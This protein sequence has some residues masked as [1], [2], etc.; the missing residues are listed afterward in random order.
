TVLTETE[1]LDS[2]SY[3]PKTKQ[4][5]IAYEEVLSTMVASLGD[6]PQDVLRG[7]AD[8]VLAWL[9]DDSLTDHKRQ[10]GVEAILG[11]LRPERF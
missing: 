7:A 10:E 6:Q 8:E 11:K 4:S 3:R 1:E 2:I 5:R 9:K